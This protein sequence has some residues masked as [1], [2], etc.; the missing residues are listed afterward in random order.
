MHAHYF[1]HGPFLHHYIVHLSRQSK[2][3]IILDDA[4]FQSN[5]PNLKKLAANCAIPVKDEAVDQRQTEVL[6]P[7]VSE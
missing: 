6:V 1:L 2:T 5:A 4:S 7:W 3:V